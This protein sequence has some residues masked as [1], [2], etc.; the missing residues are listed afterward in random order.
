MGFTLLNSSTEDG[1]T[2]KKGK[3]HPKYFEMV[4]RLSKIAL[5]N[6]LHE[7]VREWL[8]DESNKIDEIA[9]AFEAVD[10]DCQMKERKR[11]VRTRTN[12]MKARVELHQKKIQNKQIEWEEEQNNLE[13]DVESVPFDPSTVSDI[14]LDEDTIANDLAEEE[15]LASLLQVESELLPLPPL[16][17]YVSRIL[18]KEI[19]EVPDNEAVLADASESIRVDRLNQIEKERLEIV[20]LQKEEEQMLQEK[21]EQEARDLLAASGDLNS[22]PSTATLPS[23]GGE[24]SSILLNEEDQE[25]AT[26]T[27]GAEGAEVD[28]EN[29][30]SEAQ[31]GKKET[32][33]D[34]LLTPT[35][36]DL[37]DRIQ[38]LW[39][40]HYQ[41]LRATVLYSRLNTEGVHSTTPFIDLPTPYHLYTGANG[42]EE[43]VMT[44][45]AVVLELNTLPHT[46]LG[47]MS[48]VTEFTMDVP[49]AIEG[50]ELAP[51]N[52]SILQVRTAAKQRQLNLISSKKEKIELQIQKEKEIIEAREKATKRGE[53]PDDAE[54][55]LRNDAVP[56]L[57]LQ[58]MTLMGLNSTAVPLDTV[59]T[60]KEKQLSI[61]EHRNE[62]LLLKE[63][64]LLASRASVR[65]CKGKHIQ[66]VMKCCR[67]MWNTIWLGWISPYE[68]GESS[69]HITAEK[70]ALKWAKID[71]MK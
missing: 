48:T 19:F 26:I 35:E 44:R 42:S 24:G 63:I 18:C 52:P 65:G 43:A 64:L 54:Q 55:Q 32:E 41:L 1:D 69:T 59:R 20:R 71:W 8:F 16:N 61:V 66:T 15:E 36:A 12:K 34:E 45:N 62:R 49:L 56:A 9:I 14:E 47:P 46:S 58:P 70:E 25:V 39:L 4:C 37:S 31:E 10:R 6:N 27:E 29:K 17:P 2:S 3:N 67:Q 23:M 33:R 5:K 53:N 30:E 13:D 38:L 50:D 11:K 22:E 28:S 60:K 51:R 57:S 7:L 21:E 40:A 68:F